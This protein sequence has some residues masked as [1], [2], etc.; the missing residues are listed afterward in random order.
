M[1]FPKR[2]ESM[3]RNGWNKGLS[4]KQIADKLNASQTAQKSGTTYTVRSIAAKL[5]NLTR[6]Q[7]VY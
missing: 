5:A 3:I 2:I 6:I 7:G 4:S 1:T